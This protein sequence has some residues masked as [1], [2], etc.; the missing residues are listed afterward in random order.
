MKRGYKTIVSVLCISLLSGC[1]NRRELNELAVSVA[2][3]VDKAGDQILI[4][5]QVLNT[6]AIAG[7][8]A[9][10]ATAPV[11]VFQEK[12]DAFQETARKMTLKSTR[13]IYVGQMQML[14]FGEEFARD[15]LGKVLD[16]IS[17]DH[18]YRKDISVVIARGV[19]AE[20]IIKVLTPLEKIPA[21]KMK[22][23]LESSARAWGS[24]AQVT[25]EQLLS[26]VISRGKEPV[27]TAITLTGNPEKGNENSNVQKIEPSAQLVYNGLGVF[28]KDKLLGWLNE[29]NSIGYN[30][31]QGNIKSTSI[32][33]PCL[34]KKKEYVTVEL[35]H[36]INK[37]KVSMENGIP[38]IKLQIK[39]DGA[40]TEAQ[41][42]ADLTKPQVISEL[43][44][45]TNR[46]IKSMISSS[47]QTVQSRYKS[48]IFGFG[49]DIARKYP[50]YW[51][52]VKKNWD[53]PFSKLQVNIDVNIN[54]RRI[55]KTTRSVEERMGD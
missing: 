16:H 20:E 33:I 10:A 55:F 18:E 48:D 9:G 54:I 2:I 4:S 34:K 24:T 28:K 7:Q 17:R 39:S 37:T 49:D 23:T 6:G 8:K 13:K 31:T 21:T 40:V 47:V 38:V 19:K 3:G 42:A 43:E 45:L 35:L 1:W 53:E 46:R 30:F 51:G 27:V 41:C 15:G 11:T 29:E 22:V 32:R 5:N 12:G 44:N 36:T 25:F 50:K 26:D 52:E 14:I